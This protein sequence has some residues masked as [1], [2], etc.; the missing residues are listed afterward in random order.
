MN[1][2]TEDSSSGETVQPLSA[3]CHRKEAP[4][5]KERG[6]VFPHFLS[7]HFGFLASLHAPTLGGTK[8]VRETWMQ[9]KRLET[10]P[11]ISG[12]DT[13]L[14][15]PLDQW[16]QAKRIIIMSG[17]KE[18]TKRLWVVL[19]CVHKCHMQNGHA[20]NTPLVHVSKQCSL[21]ITGKHCT[22]L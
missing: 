10:H 13:W 18:S 11:Y 8:Q 21:S 5:R 2:H 1:G 20:S 4:Q 9:F 7:P 3:L 14:L 12:E 6:K 17:D 22:R 15:A 16:H 19:L